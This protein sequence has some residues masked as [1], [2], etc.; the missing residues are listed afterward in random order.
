MVSGAFIGS[1]AVATTRALAALALPTWRN[2]LGVATNVLPASYVAS[3]S[4]IVTLLVEISQSI[5]VV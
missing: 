3:R 5:T 2:S 4:G 1:I